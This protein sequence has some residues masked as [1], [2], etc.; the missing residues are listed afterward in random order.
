MAY[1]LEDVLT[2]KTNRE[3]FEKVAKHLATMQG[4]SLAPDGCHCAYAGS[5]CAVGCLVDNQAALEYWDD[6][7]EYQMG[8]TDI[9]RPSV[10]RT[11]HSVSIGL[12]E[13][14]QCIHDT[15]FSWDNVSARFI[16][17]DELVEAGIGHGIKDAA[18]IVEAAKAQ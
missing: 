11:I 15:S 17:W 3:A 8:V 2:V 13:E 16:G 6:T 1:Y 7:G 9:V 10:G 4:R 14:L 18:E 12:L 5:R